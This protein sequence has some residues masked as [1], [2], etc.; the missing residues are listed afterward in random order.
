M[1]VGASDNGSG[2]S[3][4]SGTAGDEWV[5]PEGEDIGTG[6]SREFVPPNWLASCSDTL[7]EIEETVAEWKVH[8]IVSHEEAVRLS[9]FKAHVTEVGKELAGLKASSAAPYKEQLDCV[10]AAFA[11]MIERATHAAKS[12]TEMLTDYLKTQPP[13]A[14]VEGFG[15]QRCV[16]LRKRRRA[17]MTDVMIAFHRYRDHPD[18]KALLEKLASADARNGA[19][20]IPGF[21]IE[22]EETAA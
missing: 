8:G 17:H 5:E 14:R 2:V 22:V 21:I 18:L 11:P 6:A 20:E 10:N 12:I 16:V 19:R 3:D 13:G 4:Y 7:S 9:G 15:S 1:A